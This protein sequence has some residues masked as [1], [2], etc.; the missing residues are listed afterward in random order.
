VDLSE[1]LEDAEDHGGAD[2]RRRRC[3]G[4]G[5]GGEKERRARGKRGLRVRV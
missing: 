2:A 5:S 1:K 4:D 3:S